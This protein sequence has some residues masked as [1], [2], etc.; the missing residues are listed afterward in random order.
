MP[1][2]VTG[3]IG[4]WQNSFNSGVWSSLEEAVQ[5]NAPNASGDTL[6]VVSGVL[7]ETNNSGSSNDGGTVGRPSH[8]YKLL[9]RCTF[10][11]GSI[12]A[13]Q[14]VAYIYTN[15]A[16][17]GVNYNASQFRTTIANIESRTG[18]NFFPSVPAALQTSAESMTAPLW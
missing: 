6:Y 1:V 12:T 4:Q 18:F 2:A 9:M 7:F 5:G 17:S 10:S 11:V 16:H 3:T 8:F 14:G 13:A 15:E